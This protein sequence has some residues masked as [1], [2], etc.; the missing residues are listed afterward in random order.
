MREAM[1][2]RT[3]P[4][5]RVARTT[6]RSSRTRYE[7]AL[8]VVSCVALGTGYTI[9]QGLTVGIALAILT[10]PLWVPVLCRMRWGLAILVLGALTPLSGF[11]LTEL[12]SPTHTINTSLEQQNTFLVIGLIGG[13]GMLVWAREMIG[14]AW[15]A[16]LFGVGLFTAIILHGVGSSIVWK[17]S[18]SV[19]TIIVVLAACMM[20]RSKLVEVTALAALALVSAFNDSRSATSMLAISATLLVWQWFSSRADAGRRS[21]PWRPSA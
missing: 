3:G 20:I 12:M 5:T 15:V 11:I 17:T 21:A 6:S 8:A 1:S 18:L 9:Q 14:E 13:I 19:P 7:V 16:L 4:E 2:R 10:L